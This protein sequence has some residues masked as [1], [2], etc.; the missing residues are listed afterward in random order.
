MNR[1]LAATLIFLAACAALLLTCLLWSDHLD[2]N[3]H[4]TLASAAP[5]A[6][7]SLP[8]ETPPPTA[9]ALAERAEA[10]VHSR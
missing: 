8:A 1:D 6:S 7:H 2:V 9:G 4:I 10:G 5:A 3:A